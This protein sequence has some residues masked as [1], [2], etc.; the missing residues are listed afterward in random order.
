VGWKID[1][2]RENG[3]S[4]FALAE[5]LTVELNHPVI[6][7]AVTGWPLHLL[8]LRE[9]GHEV[10]QGHPSRVNSPIAG[11]HGHP[12]RGIRVVLPVLQVART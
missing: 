1:R 5:K 3:R 12:R 11:T 2:L 9:G 6:A 8:H 4:G 7:V 10:G